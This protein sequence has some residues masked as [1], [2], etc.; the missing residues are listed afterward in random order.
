MS[1]TSV[2]RIIKETITVLVRFL[3]VP[4]SEEWGLNA[5]LTGHEFILG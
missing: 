3:K 4:A 1:K 2:Y 5:L